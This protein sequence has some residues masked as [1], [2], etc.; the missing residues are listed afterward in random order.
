MYN[1]YNISI[2]R[3]LRRRYIR[4]S[5]AVIIS[6][7]RVLVLI[8]FYVLT[9]TKQTRTLRHRRRI[10]LVYTL[11]LYDITTEALSLSL[12]LVRVFPPGKILVFTI[13]SAA[14][15]VTAGKRI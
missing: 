6:G 5:T 4:R 10:I 7:A 11:L 14:A 2:I 12:S 9:E 1:T 15:D 13:R 8:I 3:V